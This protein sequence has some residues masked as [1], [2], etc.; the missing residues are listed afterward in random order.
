MRSFCWRMTSASN[1]YLHHARNSKCLNSG[2]KQ[3]TASL[4]C[5]HIFQLSTHRNFGKNKL[6]LKCSFTRDFAWRSK[7][8]LQ[9]RNIDVFDD[10]FLEE[11]K[12]SSHLIFSRR[13]YYTMLLWGYTEDAKSSSHFTDF[14]ILYFNL[15]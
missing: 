11:Y 5:F 2:T 6:S 9:K 3:H 1:E 13:L 4:I 14:F 15:F 10:I 12:Q 7:L 8:Y